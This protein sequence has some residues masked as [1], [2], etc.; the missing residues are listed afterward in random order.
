[1]SEDRLKQHF[2]KTVITTYQKNYYTVTGSKLTG[3]ITN[4]NKQNLVGQRNRPMKIH[5]QNFAQTVRNEPTDPKESKNQTRSKN[6]IETPMLPNSIEST[7]FTGP[8]AG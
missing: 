6:T 1:M 7:I 5:A 3:T 8:L 2:N 4:C